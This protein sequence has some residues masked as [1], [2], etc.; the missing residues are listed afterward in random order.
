LA[1]NIHPAVAVVR[2]IVGV[3]PLEETIGFVPETPVTWAL[4][5]TLFNPTSAAVKVGEEIKPRLLKA[6][7]AFPE[8][9]A[10]G[11]EL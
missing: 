3:V 4:L 11:E 7:R 10:I 5:V 9:W 2:E 1:V 8:G 6:V